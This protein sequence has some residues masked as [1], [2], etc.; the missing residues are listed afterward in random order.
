MGVPDLA[1]TVDQSPRQLRRWT[2]FSLRTLLAT[3]TLL[4][5]A[6]GYVSNRAHQQR[7]V[8]ESLR[9][10]SA[11]IYYDDDL[12]PVGDEILAFSLGQMYYQ[13]TGRNWPHYNNVEPL[14]PAWLRQWL[15]D[16]YFHTVVAIDV[17]RGIPVTLTDDD[18]RRISRL[19]CLERLCLDTADGLTDADFA[20]LGRMTGLERLFLADTQIGDAGVA[21]LAGL[22]KLRYLSLAN[23]KITDAGLIQLN[24]LQHL[25]M[26]ELSDTGITDAGL[27]HL[28]HLKG[29]ATIYLYETKVTEEGA[30]ELQTALPNCKVAL[31][32]PGIVE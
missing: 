23:T 25:K 31:H 24:N 4:A 30:K 11:E 7:S 21:H 10:Q 32:Y 2:K 5:L 18:L 19:P 17:N 12:V 8:V 6:F 28:R 15:G 27:K 14:G 16:D 22:T 13:A 3:V 26:L 29:A 9:R 1:R 20:H